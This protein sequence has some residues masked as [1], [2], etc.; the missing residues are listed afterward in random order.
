MHPS[1]RKQGSSFWISTAVTAV[2][3]FD[4][5]MFCQQ[6]RFSTYSHQ[7][8]VLTGIDS[9]H[10]YWLICITFKQ[11]ANI[12][13]WYATWSYLSESILQS[14]GDTFMN[15]I[16]Y[17]DVNQQADHVVDCKAYWCRSMHIYVSPA[18]AWTDQIQVWLNH[19]ICSNFIICLPMYGSTSSTIK[20]C[21]KDKLFLFLQCEIASDV[22]CWEQ[23]VLVCWLQIV[24]KDECVVNL[25]TNQLYEDQRFMAQV[26]ST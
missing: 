15:L 3:E 5:L 2:P 25:S 13:K 26:D 17:I 7:I 19:K 11:R 6:S 4:V 23:S 9:L 10:V 24:S 12:E 1:L 14:A 21:I 22:K 18:D 16:R 8:L 20:I